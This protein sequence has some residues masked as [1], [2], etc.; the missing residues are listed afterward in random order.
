M[1]SVK[2][3]KDTDRLLMSYGERFGTSLISQLAP[4][5]MQTTQLIYHLLV[6]ALGTIL[7]CNARKREDANNC[8]TRYY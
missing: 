4:L 5:N 2:K 1:K 3:K 8:K 6:N 7:L